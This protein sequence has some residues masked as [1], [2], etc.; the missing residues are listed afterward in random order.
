MKRFF[1]T[2]TICLLLLVASKALTGQNNPFVLGHIDTLYSS[3]LDETRTLNIYLPPGYSPD[4]THT[5]PVI[6][7]LDGAADEDFIHIAGLVQFASFPWV[8]HL[9]PSILVGIANT[10]R[11]RDFT[12]PAAPG[13][14]FPKELAAYQNSHKT[15]GGSA[16][17]M[18]F[19]EKELQPYI[20][21]HY[22]VKEEKTL[23][24][25]SLAGLM[26]VEFLLKK[27]QLFNTYIIMSPS[28]WWD[29]ESLLKTSLAT[30][31]PHTRVYLAVGKEGK[32]MEG[33]ARKLAALL[34]KSKGFEEV[35]FEYWPKEDHGTILHP[36]V[37]RAFRLLKK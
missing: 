29:D 14:K 12:Y 25:Q 16:N 30:P 36:A 13:F 34:K 17:F 7:L 5:Y 19:V 26:A 27:P 9:P 11:K 23:I 4:S 1:P 18:A 21:K 3:I 31:L 24:G 33:P 22:K 10:D 8:E 35:I 28:L 37:A 6:Y 32:L 20:E 15:A 2:L